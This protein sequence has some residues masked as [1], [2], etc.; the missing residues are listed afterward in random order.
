MLQMTEQSQNLQ[1]QLNEEETGN[2]RGKEFRVIIGKMTQD[3]RKRMEA[4]IQK[5]QKCLRRT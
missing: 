4:W 5:I 2:K 3:L 1:E